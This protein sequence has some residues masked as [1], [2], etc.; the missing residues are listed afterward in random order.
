MA[1]PATTGSPVS[2]E[3]WAPFLEALEALASVLAELDAPSMFI[4][5]VAV[6]AL[7]VPRSTVDI[8]ATVVAANLDLNRLFEIAERRRFGPRVQDAPAF[9][10]LHHVVLLEHRASG[11]PIDITLASLPFEEDAIASST[12]I[13]YAGT[14]IR[15]PTPGDLLVYKVVAARPR[16]LED[17]EQLLLLYGSRLDLGRI[18]GIL[19]QFAEALEDPGR[20]ELWDRMVERL[21]R[22]AR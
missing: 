6:I 5:G 22:D 19:S 4:G 20:L 7:G 10:R 2:A 16:D 15:I 9:A 8:D 21:L 1:N 14:S 13:D 18:R 3:A 11:I 12:T 17:A